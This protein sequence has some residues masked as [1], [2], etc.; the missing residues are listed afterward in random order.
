MLRVDGDYTWCVVLVRVRPTVHKAIDNDERAARTHTPKL[1][2]VKQAQ[3][4]AQ[5]PLLYY[6]HSVTYRRATEIR[7]PNGACASYT[8]HP[9]MGH[10][11][12]LLARTTV[13]LVF[14]FVVVV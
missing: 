13:R 8:T 3:S 14:F 5:S 4:L 11:H 7:N 6:T 9:L 10:P 2:V 1:S 12:S